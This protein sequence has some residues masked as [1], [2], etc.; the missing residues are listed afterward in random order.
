MEGNKPLI[1]KALQYDIPFFEKLKGIFFA[2]R[3]QRQNKTRRR[4][5][6]WSNQREP[7]KLKRINKG[8]YQAMS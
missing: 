3:I 7:A 1:P 5:G 4:A 8:S 6:S 2:Y